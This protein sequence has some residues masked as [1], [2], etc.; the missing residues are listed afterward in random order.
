MKIN[1]T[2]SAGAGKTSWAKHFGNALD[3]P[4]HHLDAVVWQPGWKKTPPELRKR[5]ERELV[6][7]SDWVIDGVSDFVRA[8]AD[9]VVVLAVSRWRCLRRAIWRNLPYLFRSRPELPSGCPEILIFP[10]LV[11][12]IWRHQ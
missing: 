3:L 2:G 8:E 12:M 1:I 5:L 4:V 10:T 9:L 11:R 6:Q 7:Q